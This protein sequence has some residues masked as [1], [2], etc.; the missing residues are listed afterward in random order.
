MT[1]CDPIRLPDGFKGIE[2]V[3]KDNEIIIKSIISIKSLIRLQTGFLFWTR[4]VAKKK[5]DRL[6]VLPEDKMV[7]MTKY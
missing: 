2:W 3:L 5:G 7:L 4:P 1:I 6:I